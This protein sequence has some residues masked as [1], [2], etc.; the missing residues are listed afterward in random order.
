MVADGALDIAKSPFP[1]SEINLPAVPKDELPPCGGPL[2]SPLCTRERKS[3]LMRVLNRVFS[4][5]ICRITEGHEGEASGFPSILQSG[6]FKCG[7]F[8][9]GL[10]DRSDYW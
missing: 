7:V 9:T 8:I 2:G 3:C 4:E 6:L 1:Y 5:Q 10:C